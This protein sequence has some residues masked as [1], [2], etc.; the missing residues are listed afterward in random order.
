MVKNALSQN[1]TGTPQ[2]KSTTLIIILGSV[3]LV[4]WLV[5]RQTAFSSVVFVVMRDIALWSVMLY[6]TMM[7]SIGLSNQGRCPDSAA[8]QGEEWRGGILS[9]AVKLIPAVWIGIWC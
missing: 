9:G 8:W 2:K 1:L 7:H 5:L 3:E 6:L 4:F